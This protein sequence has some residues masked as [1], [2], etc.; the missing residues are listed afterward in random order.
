LTL[1]P[2]P[3]A[4]PPDPPLHELQPGDRLVRFYNPAHGPWHA[5]RF[6][7]PLAETRFDHHLPPLAVSP[8]RSVWYAAGSLIGA[9]AESFGNLRFVDKGAQRK[10]CVAS[11]RVP[12]PLLDLV[13]VA[14]RV[15][16]LDQRIGTSTDYGRTQEWARAFYDAYGDIRGLRWRGRQAGA[17]CVALTDRAEMED[18]EV[19]VDHD[20]SHP[21][22]WPRIARA[23]HRAHLRIVAP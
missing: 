9:V 2:P 5:Q 12:V 3:A 19:V 15:F 11:V 23:A 17:L 7:G 14:P 6:Y 22:V 18:L 10:V 4:L 1:T 20:L 16:G 8:D 21:G 13:G